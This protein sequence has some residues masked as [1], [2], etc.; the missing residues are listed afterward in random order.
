MPTPR[1]GRPPKTFP[2][3][4]FDDIT[5]KLNSERALIK[6]LE[7]VRALIDSMLLEARAT[8][9]RLAALMEVGR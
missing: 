8:E 9:A 6:R 5:Y 7:D 1:T 2:A 4:T 3:L